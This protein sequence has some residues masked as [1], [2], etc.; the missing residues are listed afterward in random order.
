MFYKIKF[1][2]I[3]WRIWICRTRGCIEVIVYVVNCKVQM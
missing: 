1:I 3:N 2:Y